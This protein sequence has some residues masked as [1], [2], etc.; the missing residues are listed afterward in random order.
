MKN[1]IKYIII[2][3]FFFS[4]TA[5]N[6]NAQEGWNFGLKGGLN[7]AWI[8]APDVIGDPLPG[9]FGTRTSFNAGLFAEYG[10]NEHLYFQVLLNL[11]QRGFSYNESEGNKSADI[12][13]RASFLEVPLL[14]RYAIPVSDK[15]DIYGLLGPSFAYLIGGRVVGE[16]MVN[17]VSGEVN[18]KI[19]DNYNT[20]DFGIKAGLGIEI[21]FADDKGATFF[22]VRYN[23]GFG[24]NIKQ[25]GYYENSNIDAN[26]Q[27]LSFVV[28]V[29]GY[30]E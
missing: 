1:L 25:G 28:G 17:G 14:I 18:N 3:C 10:F 22:D 7:M 21:P 9:T 12:T 29:K 16:K 15:F 2:T 8:S 5:L 13:L 24:D 11:D 26:S 20:T 23:Y 19:T 27:V 4:I 30:I 6:L